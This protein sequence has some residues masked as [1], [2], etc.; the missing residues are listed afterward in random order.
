VFAKAHYVC[1]GLL[2]KKIQVKGASPKTRLVS[3]LALGEIVLKPF[4][5][6]KSKVA[7]PKLKFW[8]CLKGLD[9]FFDKLYKANNVSRNK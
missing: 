7:V 2:C 1:Q 4:F 5:S 8:D 9:K 3:V 6:L